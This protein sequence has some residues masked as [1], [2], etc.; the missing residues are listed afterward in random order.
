MWRRVTQFVYLA[1]G[2][3]CQNVKYKQQPKALKLTKQIQLFFNDEL[4][5]SFAIPLL[6]Y[7]PF[8]LPP[9]LK[10][11]IFLYHPTI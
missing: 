3:C 5:K 8:M 10:L 9:S 2:R 4:K 6:Y 1:R 11:F 7:P